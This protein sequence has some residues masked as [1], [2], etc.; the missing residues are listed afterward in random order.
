MRKG[1]ILA[2]LLLAATSAVSAQGTQVLVEGWS[3]T[4]VG[5][6]GVPNGWRTQSW[7]SPKY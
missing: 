2:V 7:G 1:S 5:Q 3:K 4:P 6:K